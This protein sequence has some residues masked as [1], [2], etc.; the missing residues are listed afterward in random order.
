MPVS[1]RIFDLVPHTG[2]LKACAMFPI[3]AC[4]VVQISHKKDMSGLQAKKIE[5]LNAI[6]IEMRVCS[7]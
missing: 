2:L 1:Y 7:C 5:F 4:F 6:D 3:Y